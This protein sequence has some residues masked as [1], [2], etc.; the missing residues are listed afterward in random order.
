MLCV[1]A[2]IVHYEYLESGKTILAEICSSLFQKG[3]R[4]IAPKAAK[5]GQQNR[6]CLARRYCVTSYGK[7]D[8]KSD[9]NNRLE[10]FTVFTLFPGNLAEE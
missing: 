4:C 5:V 8:Q 2:D 3:F 10:S 1:C 9:Q 7:N 6:S